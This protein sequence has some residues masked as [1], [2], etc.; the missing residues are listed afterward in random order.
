[1]FNSV[2]NI[3]TKNSKVALDKLK[4][5]SLLIKETFEDKLSKSALWPLLE[6]ILDLENFFESGKDFIEVSVNKMRQTHGPS[7]NYNTVKAL[8][9]LR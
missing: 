4:A 3:K 1:M 7:F 8:L 9:A 6:I 5:D 2:K